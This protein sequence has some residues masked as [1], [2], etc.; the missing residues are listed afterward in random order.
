MAIQAQRAQGGS[1]KVS[2]AVAEL[3][4]GAPGAT[5]NKTLNAATGALNAGQLVALRPAGA[6]PTDTVV[7][8]APGTPVAT[9]ASGPVQVGLSWPAGTDNVGVAS[10]RINRNGTLIGHSATT[11]FTD[12][13]VT[14]STGYSYTVET[15]DAAGNRSA[16]STAVN[17]TTQAGYAGTLAT[18]YTWSPRG[19]L[20]T[21]DG[22]TPTAVGFDALGRQ[23]AWGATAYTY[24]DLDRIATRDA[25]AFG[26]AGTEIDPVAVGGERYSRTPAGELLAVQVN[27]AA[28]LV[29]E[30]R[31]GDVA[32]LLDPTGTVTD[33][34]IWDPYGQ[35]AGATGTT[36][37]AVGYQ[38]D[39][40]DPDTG[41]VWM[42]ARWYMPE[43][44]GFTSRD[45]VF[46]MLKTPIS[47]NRYTYGNGDPLEHFDPDGRFSIGLGG[48]GS[49]LT[50]F[51]GAR[52]SKSGAGSTAGKAS[53][54][55]QATTS[56]AATQAR[57]QAN[58]QQRKQLGQMKD[59]LKGHGAL[60]AGWNKAGAD[61]QAN[62]FMW[63]VLANGGK[64]R[65]TW[66][67]FNALNPE[68]KSAARTKHG[69]AALRRIADRDC[70]GARVAVVCRNKQRIGAVAT[71]ALAIGVG[72]I[73]AGTASGLTTVALASAGI[74]GTG[75]TI[76]AA[77][78]GGIA[79]SAASQR[80]ATGKV[81]GRALVRDGAIAAATAG[82]ASGFSA[83]RQARA[84]ATAA[85]RA[86]PVGGSDVPRF[87]AAKEGI[88]DTA[89]P[90]LRQQ[91]DDVA[92]SMATTGAAPPGV[93]QGGLPGK[94]GVY[95]NRNGALPQQPEGYYHET[96]VW[97]GP[98]PRGTE[99]LVTGANGEVW[100]TPDHYGTFRQVQ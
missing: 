72:L 30:N 61:T 99:R 48:L 31:H 14:A 59:Y 37:P 33:S 68:D 38:G 45:S 62:Y 85:P 23:T 75:A 66:D 8:G 50:A 27:G 82:L 95:G 97:P 43:T 60:P 55:Q 70:D 53:A 74:T 42:G 18:A 7:P 76:T 93:R 24:D 20:S 96:D 6:E 5:G 89:A 19:T 86:M 56:K 57:T 91:I 41:D 3:A 71:G 58:Q 29:G 49:R 87:V 39:Y 17:V 34:R 22:G 25:T 10:Y 46:G 94:P 78:V 88:I 15:V 40:T 32:W 63:A 9:P 36:N 98:G 2:V 51:F 28:R 1:N 81:D 67:Q 47:L 65:K 77:A 12:T 54:S 92:N 100:Y 16:P 83:L 79:S 52:Q 84:G 13:Q 64:T 35:P 44:G 73:T 21:V 69:D 90:A 80:V 11:S 4:L 26:Y